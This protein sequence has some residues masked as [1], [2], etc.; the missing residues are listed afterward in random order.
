M[1]L[2]SN[3]FQTGGETLTISGSNFDTSS[4]LTIGDTTVSISSIT[5]TTVTAVLPAMQPGNYPIKLS[6]SSGLAVDG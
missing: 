1:I 4:T 3:I 6:G 2:K 5:T